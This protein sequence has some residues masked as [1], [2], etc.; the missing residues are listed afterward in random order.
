MKLEL[1]IPVGVNA[2]YKQG[3]H[4]WYKSE[5]AQ[6]WLKEALWAMKMQGKGQDKPSGDTVY[7]TWVFADKR[8]RDIDSG[9]KL[10][11]DAIV[12][13]GIIKDDSQITFLQVQKTKGYRNTCLVEI[14]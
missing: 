8:K 12:T 10:L 13:A 3:K 4:G 9:I 11:L 1:P 6:V 5:K 7:I 14:G 2:L